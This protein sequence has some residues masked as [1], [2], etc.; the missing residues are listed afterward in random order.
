MSLLL[1]GTRTAMQAIQSEEAKSSEPIKFAERT[2]VNEIN[3]WK[4]KQSMEP[5]RAKAVKPQTN[6]STQNDF[7]SIS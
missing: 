7:V 6:A 4:G 2:A 5:H 3:G 1:H